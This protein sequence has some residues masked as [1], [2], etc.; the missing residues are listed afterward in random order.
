M[1]NKIRHCINTYP[2]KSVFSGYYFICNYSIFCVDT[3]HAGLQFWT[4]T[5][6]F[7]AKLLK[8]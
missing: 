1:Q 5:S 7:M 2:F 4:F 3:S 6:F 8:F